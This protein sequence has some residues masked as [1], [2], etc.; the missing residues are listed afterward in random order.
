[1][2]P[3]YPKMGY[4]WDIDQ[5]FSKV[6]GTR[7]ALVLL[8]KGVGAQHAPA[9]TDDATDHRAQQQP[10][11]SHVVALDTQQVAG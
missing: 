1:M 4:K 7:V 6:Q 11:T 2:T 5:P 3:K 9:A 10:P 8:R